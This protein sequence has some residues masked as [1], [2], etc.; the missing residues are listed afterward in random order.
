[1]PNNKI[2]T[3]PNQKIIEGRRGEPLL[4]GKFSSVANNSKFY[5]MRNLSLNAYKVWSYFLSF[6]PKVEWALS[7]ADMTFKCNFSH[8]TYRNV[9][10]ELMD[11]GFLEPGKKKNG[12]VFVELPI[13]IENLTNENGEFVF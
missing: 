8:E 1:M 13:E 4:P 9:I 10:K 7:K 11:K 3:Y 6:N 2:K 12:F 5:T